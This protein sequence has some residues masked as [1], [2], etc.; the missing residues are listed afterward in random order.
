VSH[1]GLVNCW[2]MLGSSP[3]NGW[4]EAIAG[5]YP[6]C[7][8]DDVLVAGAPQEAI[9]LTMQAL[10]GPGDRV[11]VLTPCYQS[12]LEMPRQ[13]GSE[14]VHWPLRRD[15]TTGRFTLD[16]ELLDDLLAEPCKLVV[17]NLPH[18]PTGTHPTKQEWD[19]LAEKIRD[20]GAYWFSDEMYRGLARGNGE[21]LPPAAG[22]A[23]RTV[24][25]WGLSK[26][27]GLPG[28]RLG[29]IVTHD[30]LLRDAIEARKDY[31]SICSN[32]L[33]ERLGI[34]ALS[35]ADGMFERYRQLIEGNA[36][37]MAQLAARHPN[38][39]RWLPPQGGPVG[40]C[41]VLQGSATQMAEAVRAEGGLLVPSR[42]FG[43]EDRWVRVGLGRQGFDAA[44]ACWER[45]LQ[46]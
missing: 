17:T 29:W 1:G 3:R 27:F 7:S 19:T 30:G 32:A 16:W 18:N 11:V 21:E 20:V 39:M 35:V 31:T 9:S 41:E 45:A 6:G 15:A 12:L 46:R 2:N 23:E 38:R 42:L 37:R 43:M 10:L 34:G 13:F 26:S 25:L 5:H 14:V 33:S 4:L 40:L 36:Q 24:S 28:L 8:A 44:L 22:T